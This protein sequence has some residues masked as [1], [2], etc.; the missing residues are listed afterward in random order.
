[1][2]T[3]DA[4]SWVPAKCEY[5]L[6][7][8]LICRDV[9]FKV[10][11]AGP[12][13][14][15]LKALDAKLCSPVLQPSTAPL[16][17]D[18]LS[19]LPDAEVPSPSTLQQHQAEECDDDDSYISEGEPIECCEA[20]AWGKGHRGAWWRVRPSLREDL[21][22][23]SGVSLSSAELRRAVPGETLQQKGKPRVILEGRSHGCIRMPVE[24]DGWVTADA[25][26]AGGPQFLTRVHA[27]RWKV[28]YQAVVVRASEELTSKALLSLSCGDVTEQ[29]GPT[30]SLADGI[31]RMPV[32]TTGPGKISGWVTVD[33]TAVGGPVL[34]KPVPENDSPGKGQ[35]RGSGRGAQKKEEA[36]VQKVSGSRD[37]RQ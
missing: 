9:L 3:F 14:N 12:P 36:G 22:V 31:L 17:K 33:A 35:G 11:A 25:S 23:R 24:P 29:A 20:V 1:M 37:G 6:L 34:F 2:A 5:G 10:L 15:R 13:V 19:P 7:H 4:A 30:I 26:R 16:A 21:V 28:V 32:T 8:L 27:P 18:A